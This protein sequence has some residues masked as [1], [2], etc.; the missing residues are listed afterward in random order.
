V[1]NNKFGQN[2]TKCH[3]EQSFHVIKSMS[4]FN[5]DQTNFKLENKH[6]DV[7]CKK[8]H[9]TKFTDHIRHNRC[10]DCHNDYHKGQFTKQGVSPDCSECH[11]TAGFTSFSFS[12]EKHNSSGFKLEGAHLATPCFACHKKQEKWA[13]NNIGEKCAD[14][15]DDIHKSYIDKKYYPQAAC[16]SCHTVDKWASI[17]F[18]HAKTGYKLEGKHQNPT[19]RA[20]HF[21]TLANGQQLQRF[22]T[23]T[24][25]CNECH[26]DKH[27]GQFEID[28]KTDCMKCH[29][30]NNWKAG[31][32]DHSKTHF[33]LDGKH[34]NVACSACHKEK[35]RGGTTF[36]QYKINKFRCENCH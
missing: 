6:R 9:K 26:N 29:D 34:I 5:H 4:S 28:G 19:C 8:C 7:E 12:I 31:K 20:C 15:H 32:F 14:C 10:T 23:L 33:P 16:K 27:F 17:N 1:H 11:S 36:V 30:F 21:E 25:N 3:S 2:C 35:Q 13:F 24:G 22:G 18:D